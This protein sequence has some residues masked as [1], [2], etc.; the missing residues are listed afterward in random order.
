M[1]YDQPLIV[2][3]VRQGKCEFYWFGMGKY[4]YENTEKMEYS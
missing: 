1:R 2:A 4:L 3:W